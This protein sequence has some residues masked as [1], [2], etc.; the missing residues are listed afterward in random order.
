MSADAMMREKFEIIVILEGTV[1]ST[2]QSSNN[3]APNMAKG[4]G[5]P[6]PPLSSKILANPICRQTRDPLPPGKFFG[7]FWNFN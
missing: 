1:E 6:K 4:T 3:N 7:T 5:Q 2:G